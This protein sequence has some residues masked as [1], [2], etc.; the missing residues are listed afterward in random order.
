MYVRRIFAPLCLYALV[1]VLVFPA[2]VEAD[3][4]GI[5]KSFKTDMTRAYVPC[6]SGITFPSPNTSSV[7]GTPG[8]AP[9]TPYSNYL[10]SDKGK[11]SLKMKSRFESPCSDG[12][13][14][15]CSNFIM[16]A[17]CSGI[18]NPDGVTPIFRQA[19]LPWV[20]AIILV[21]AVVNDLNRESLV[22][23]SRV[24][25]SQDYIT[26]S[27]PVEFFLEPSKGKLKGV[28]STIESAGVAMVGPGTSVSIIGA[29][30]VD[31]SGNVFAVSGSSTR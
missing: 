14:P 10:F 9:P 19:R 3:F 31:P 20:L 15:A 28:G 1:A 7:S 29:Q 23:G 8:C 24:A 13:S 27:V 2:Q 12:L 18:T 25:P 26:V 17:K 11:C 16:Q 21:F 30:I 5:A 6:G 22:D 4:P